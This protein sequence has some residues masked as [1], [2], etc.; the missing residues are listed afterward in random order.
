[1]RPT[2]RP[3]EKAKRG[4]RRPDSLVAVT[5]QLHDRFEAEPWRTARE[6]LEQLQDERPG[7]YGVGLLRTLQRR[8]KG[9]RRGKAHELVFETTPAGDELVP[10]PLHSVA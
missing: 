9:W 4:R 2:S 5:A 8:L 6:L 7:T 1:M 3:K 10:T